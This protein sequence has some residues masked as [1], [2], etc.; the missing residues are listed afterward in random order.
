MDAVDQETAI[1]R[2]RELI[3]EARIVAW[4]LHHGHDPFVAG[5]PPPDWLT[6][7]VTPTLVWV[8]VEGADTPTR[9]PAGTDSTQRSAREMVDDLEWLSR[10]LAKARKDRDEARLWAWGREHGMF[11]FST[12]DPPLWLTAS[13]LPADPAVIERR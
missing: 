13:T 10:N 9:L 4:E 7:D 5:Y 1:I 6:S 3:D 2:L 8:H 11:P 12:A